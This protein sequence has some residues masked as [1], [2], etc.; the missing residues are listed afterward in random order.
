MTPDAIEDWR[1][2]RVGILGGTFDPPHL[3]H[4]RMA[5][6]AR[7]A[8][9]LERVFLS[10]A[11]HPPHKNDAD[12]T[13]Y[14]HRRAMLEIAIA[15]EARTTVTSV[16]ESHATSY[17]VD[18]LR[19]CRERTSADLY[20]IMGADSLASMSTWRDPADVMRLAT[21]VIFPR[22]SG[23]VRAPDAGEASLVVFESPVIEVSSRE[24]RER[25][26]RGETAV[27]GLA[28]AV[29]RY[30]AHHRLYARA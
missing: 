2:N 30:V 13:A 10:P 12:T 29:A 21:L 18:L 3:G 7:E 8:L 27:E 28:P 24:I 19:A 9:G 22:G 5:A 1:G 6:A 20:L 23:M 14:I 17:T 15:G 11:P 25:L 16:E 4:T 26:A